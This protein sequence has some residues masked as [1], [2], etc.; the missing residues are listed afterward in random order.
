MFHVSSQNTL[1]L[2]YLLMCRYK[3]S[4]V[5]V[6]YQYKKV[7]KRHLFPSDLSIFFRKTNTIVRREWS[8]WWGIPQVI[9]LPYRKWE[10]MKEERGEGSCRLNDGQ[11]VWIEVWVLFNGSYFRRVLTL[12]KIPQKWTLRSI[13]LKAPI[14]GKRTESEQ[15]MYIPFR[16]QHRNICP[17]LI[18][19]L[20]KR[21]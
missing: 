3:M 10:S 6:V 1:Y 18:H 17:Y 13:S 21:L 11:E 20:Y 16:P 14:Q 12:P 5:M 15:K 9:S 4:F 2:R 7:Q 8:H 19:T